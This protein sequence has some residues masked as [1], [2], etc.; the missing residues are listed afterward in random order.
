MTGFWSGYYSYDMTG[1]TVL[2][3][4]WIAEEAGLFTGLVLEPNTLFYSDDEELEAEI[5]GERHGLDVIFDKSYLPD[6]G[7]LQPPVRY[8][9]DIDPEFSTISGV[10]FFDDAGLPTGIFMLTRTSGKL[11]RES[12]AAG[13]RVRDRA[14]D[15]G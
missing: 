11:L 10:W 2:F 13:K 7:V 6:S 15:A 9:G 4:A 8:Q 5:A 3:T 12:S 1:E 14:S